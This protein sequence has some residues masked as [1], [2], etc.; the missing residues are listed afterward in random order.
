M[1]T[2]LLQPGLSV[3]NVPSMAEENRDGR[4]HRRLVGSFLVYLVKS[5]TARPWKSMVRRRGC[6]RDKTSNSW[7]CLQKQMPSSQTF[8][9]KGWK[10]FSWGF[11]SSFLGSPIFIMKL[12]RDNYIGRNPQISKKE[13]NKKNTTNL[14]LHLPNLTYSSRNHS[15]AEKTSWP[16][17]GNEGMNPKYTNVKVHSL[18]PY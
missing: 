9:C 5:S 3:S 8:K 2:G 16:L 12:I 14:Q 4:K 6:F 10:I 1:S 13:W 11:F 15:S 7:K 17:V 18:I